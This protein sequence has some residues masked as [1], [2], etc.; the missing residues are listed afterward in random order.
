[1]THDSSRKRKRKPVSEDEL[2]EFLRRYGRKAPKR[3]EPNDRQYDRRL[4]ERIKRLP[5]E[6]FDDL[7][8]GND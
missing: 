4:E 5:P 8:R 3:G 7:L 6:E 2:S 1:M